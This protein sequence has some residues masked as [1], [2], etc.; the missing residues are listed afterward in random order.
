M[1]AGRTLR[2]LL[3]R[4]PVLSVAVLG[5]IG[6]AVSVALFGP[7]GDEP[8]R[9][10][11]RVIERDLPDH[12]G[13]DTH[14]A[15]CDTAAAQARAGDTFECRATVGDR[16]IPFVAEM[17][18]DQS[19]VVN[20]D[21][22]ILP[23]DDVRDLESALRPLITDKHGVELPPDNVDCGPS[24]VIANRHHQVGC[25]LRHPIDDVVYDTTVTF[26]DQGTLVDIEISGYPR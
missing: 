11:E 20:P 21:R 25:G 23:E 24:P 4:S 18:D 3:T 22:L 12:L 14:D 7:D 5:L 2:Q 19:V 10:A 8:H 9:A 6:T 1:R 13:I 26:D 16:E 17:V 15:E